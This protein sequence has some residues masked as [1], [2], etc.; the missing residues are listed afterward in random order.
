[1]QLVKDILR[2]AH[3]YLCCGSNIQGQCRLFCRSQTT[4]RLWH[5]WLS[6]RPKCCTRW[7]Y[8]KAS[9]SSSRSC[10]LKTIQTSTRFEYCPIQDLGG[11][12]IHSYSGSAELFLHIQIQ[13]AS[14]HLDITSACSFMYTLSRRSKIIEPY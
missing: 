2:K 3:H 10:V 13:A 8:A 6:E 12:K 14:R 5:E 9:C 7:S 1:M 4:K 11:A